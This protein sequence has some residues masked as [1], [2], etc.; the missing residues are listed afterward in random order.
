MI[1]VMR[2]RVFLFPA[3]AL[4]IA[5]LGAACTGWATGTTPAAQYPK[6][7]LGLWIPHPQPC[8][9]KG[10]TYEGDVVMDISPGALQAHEDSSRP[11]RVELISSQPMV[12]RIE[13][14]IELGPSGIRDSPSIFVLGTYKLTVVTQHQSE[15]YKRC[16]SEN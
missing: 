13:S 8:P 16:E 2:H 3:T 14:I 1:E 15:I 5:S 4:L 6:E 12:W 7:L 11:T 10:D 9:E